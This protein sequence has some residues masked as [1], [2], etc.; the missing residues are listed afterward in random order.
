[1]ID[2][3][4][5]SK[6]FDHVEVLKNLSCHI[7]KNVPTALLGPS[8]AGKSTLL[9]CING[10]ISMDEGKIFVGNEELPEKAKELRKFQKGIGIIFQQFNLV[11]RLTVLENVLCGR[12]A[13]TSFW[14]SILKQFSSYDY[15][16]AGYYL[17][18]VGLYEKRFQRASCLS[19]GQQ[20]RVAIARALIQQP[21]VL[22]ADEPVASLD[23]KTAESIM[24]LLVT[25]SREEGITLVVTLHSI[26]LAMKYSEKII[27]LNHGRIMVSYNTGNVRKEELYPLYDDAPWET[28]T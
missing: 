8:G 16:L 12:L 18:K 27:G 7:D 10:L 5:L 1:M 23:P 4:H 20:Q 21:Q 26:D 11:K 17:Q 2:I 28:A 6:S 25:I 15:Q 9:R 13:Y 22:L 24:N 3:Q 14:R 19:G